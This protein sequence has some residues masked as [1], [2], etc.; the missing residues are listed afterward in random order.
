MNRVL[1][2]CFLVV[3]GFL[4]PAESVAMVAAIELPQPSVKP[5]AAVEL[6][7]PDVKP[8]DAREL[9]PVRAIEAPYNS[10][11]TE[12]ALLTAMPPAQN[13]QND[14]IQSTRIPEP[15][16]YKPVIKGDYIEAADYNPAV[17]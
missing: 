5:V 10:G 6:P 13:K 15:P 14:K 4:C 1:R 8:V 9:E 16:A 12:V 3:A 11:I 17:Y 7:P 2:L